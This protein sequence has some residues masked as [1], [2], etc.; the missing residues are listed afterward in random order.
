[1]TYIDSY[2]PLDGIYQMTDNIEKCV[3]MKCEKCGYEEKVL[4]SDIELHREFSSTDEEDHL[5]CPFCLN[6]MFR[7]DSH[8]FI[9]IESE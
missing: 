3:L 6:D 7:K 2:N 5:L 8:H 1:M 4:L 9:K